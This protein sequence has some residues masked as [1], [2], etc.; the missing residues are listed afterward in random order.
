MLCELYV[1]KAVK[2]NLPKPT[3]VEKRKATENDRRN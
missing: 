3:V 1:S 2:K